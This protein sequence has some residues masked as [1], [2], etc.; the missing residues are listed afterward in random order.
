MFPTISELNLLFRISGRKSL[1]VEG[2][3]I[4]VAAFGRCSGRF[5]GCSMFAFRKFS[6]CSNKLQRRSINVQN[7]LLNLQKFIK[8]I[9]SA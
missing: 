9:L 2:F 8:L 3:M 4:H 7:Q 6:S 5:R 1:L